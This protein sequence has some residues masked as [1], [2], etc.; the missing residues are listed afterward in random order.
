MPHLELWRP[1]LL[2]ALMA[3]ATSP[4][5]AQEFVNPADNAYASATPEDVASAP[6]IAD[7]I[8]AEIDDATLSRALNSESLLFDSTKVK[9][10]S[11]R[12]D[13]PNAAK[14]NRVDNPDGSA[15]YSVNKPLA[16]P[17]DSKVGADLSTAAP[18]PQAT[19]PRTLPSTFSSDSGSGSAWANLAVPNVATVEVRAEPGNGYDKV[20]TKLERSVPLGKSLSVTAQSTLGVMESRPSTMISTLTPSPDAAARL[21]STDNSLQLNVLATGTSLAAGTSTATGDPMTHS[22]FSAG[23]KV[24]GPLNVTGTINDP[25]QASRNLSLTA[26]MKFDW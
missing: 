11:R 20:G 6:K 25:G 9:P 21:F 18:L 19:T 10:L 2:C 4:A 3:F 12:D 5:A 23:Q 7:R 17:W 22:R 13:S 1:V 24:Y 8:P 14:W 16:T 26:G 15:S